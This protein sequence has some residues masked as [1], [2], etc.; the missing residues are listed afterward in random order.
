MESKAQQESRVLVR[1]VL[2]CVTCAIQASRQLAHASFVSR[3]QVLFGN[4]DE[5][6][7]SNRR[8]EICTFDVDDGKAMRPGPCLTSC[9]HGTQ[10]LQRLQWWGRPKRDRVSCRTSHRDQRACFDSLALDGSPL[11]VSTHYVVMTLQPIYLATSR[12]TFLYTPIFLDNSILS[13]LACTANSQFS[14]FQSSTSSQNS[15]S[16]HHFPALNLCTFFMRTLICMLHRIGDTRSAN[17]AA[18]FRCWSEFQS[19]ENTI[20]IVSGR[21]VETPFSKRV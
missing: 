10:E 1:P 7:S 14:V 2:G 6:R 5:D 3:F 18:F 12:G 17:R 20:Q 21:T 13:F 16:L 8:V 15:M 19:A 9:T 11:F 4:F